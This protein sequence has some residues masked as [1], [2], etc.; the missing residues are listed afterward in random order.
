MFY[1]E[2]KSHKGK[3]IPFTAI[4][5]N[6]KDTRIYEMA[7]KAENKGI[8]SFIIFNWRDCD[9]ETYAVS[10]ELVNNFINYADRKSIPF[11]WVKE[12]GVRIHHR[13]KRVR[14]SYDIGNFLEDFK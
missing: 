10:A 4:C 8:F 3:S 6:S 12:N 5:K 1:L 2:L 13:L 11:D 9:N 14:Y 7:M